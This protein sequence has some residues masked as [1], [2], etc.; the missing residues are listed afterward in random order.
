MRVD[1]IDIES[2]PRV[3]TVGCPYRHPPTS[4]RCGL[5]STWSAHIF[6]PQV[7]RK[8]PSRLTNQ[9]TSLTRD[10][11][12]DLAHVLEVRADIL[13]ARLGDCVDVSSILKFGQGSSSLLSRMP[14]LPTHSIPDIHT[15]ENRLHRHHSPSIPT[16]AAH[17][18]HPLA[19]M[20]PS[21]VR[22]TLSPHFHP[23][24]PAFVPC[25]PN[26]HPYPNL[27]ATSIPPIEHPA[28]S[29]QKR[30]TLLGVRGHNGGRGV[31]NLGGV[32]FC[33]HT[34]N[35]FHRPAALPYA[36]LLY[37]PEPDKGFQS[38]G[39]TLRARRRGRW[40][41]GERRRARQTHHF[42]RERGMY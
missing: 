18:R 32:S 19:P 40:T 13:A 16:P 30:H 41:A 8:R 39:A 38:G 5:S 6:R 29:E 11:S 26:S 4:T 36:A 15:R 21:S 35:F 42:W 17:A 24:H 28:S 22:T 10:G 3:A 31:A 1:R 37:T 2:T 12:G 7:P 27:R 20:R 33:I 9:N 14:I 23:T 34:H 25:C